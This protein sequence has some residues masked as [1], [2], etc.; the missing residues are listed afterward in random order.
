MKGISISL[1]LFFSNK[2]LSNIKKVIVITPYTA[3]VCFDKNDKHNRKGIIENNKYFSEL[4]TNI[5]M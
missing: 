4:I 1:I 5:N 3:G 2:Q